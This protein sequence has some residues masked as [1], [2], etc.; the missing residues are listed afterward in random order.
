MEFGQWGPIGADETERADVGC[1]LQ[2][3]RSPT[4]T[5]KGDYS[6]IGR[7]IE[8]FRFGERRGVDFKLPRYLLI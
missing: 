4:Q 6:Q 7:Q 3:S 2:K 1:L 8:D 5:G